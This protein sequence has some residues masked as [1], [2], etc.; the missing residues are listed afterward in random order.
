[1]DHD[2]NEKVD[3]IEG[4]R[5]DDERNYIQENEGTAI[6]EGHKEK[7]NDDERNF[8]QENEDAAIQDGPGKLLQ[9]PEQGG[10][11]SD[12][13]TLISEEA[14]R[15][16][17]DFSDG[18]PES[19]SGDE[20]SISG[21]TSSNL[22][23]RYQDDDESSQ[24]N[25]KSGVDSVLSEESSSYCSQMEVMSPDNH[26][27][28]AR[29]IVATTKHGRR[30]KVSTTRSGTGLRWITST[31]TKKK[32][33]SQD[34]SLASAI[35][36]LSPLR[37]SQSR[38]S[39]L[40]LNMPD[41]LPT[42]E[43]H[44]PPLPPPGKLRIVRCQHCELPLQVPDD[45]PPNPESLQ[46]L[47]CRSCMN[48]STFS[49]PQAEGPNVG[50][51]VSFPSS[52]SLHSQSSL[53]S[54]LGS[55][56]LSATD[57]DEMAERAPSPGA[58]AL[59]IN[60]FSAAQQAA[61]TTSETTSVTS[62]ASSPSSNVSSMKF[63][64]WSDHEPS[65]HEEISKIASN[66]DLH[67]TAL[68]PYP[69]SSNMPP[70]DSSHRSHFPALRPY[71]RFYNMPPNSSQ[72]SHFSERVLGGVSSS[73]QPTFGSDIGGI[74]YPSL[75]SSEKLWSEIPPTSDSDS[76]SFLPSLLP[77]GSTQPDESSSRSP[78]ITSTRKRVYDDE[79][80]E[81][82]P[83]VLGL[84]KTLNLNFKKT[85]RTGG[86]QYRRYRRKVIVNGVRIPDHL[87]KK[88]EQKAGPIHPGTY[89]WASLYPTFTLFET[90][91]SNCHWGFN[92]ILLVID[93]WKS[94]RYGEAQ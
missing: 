11:S 83:D 24:D 59:F 16:E 81:Q 64:S 66:H 75:P 15:S 5:T 57:Q 80:N 79:P 20:A 14:E 6:R 49:I 8:I 13:A 62:S 48:V 41:Q 44:Y 43:G 4:K 84:R 90:L 63:S 19:D 86:N 69:G 35:P 92:A 82:L 34:P 40:F 23:V 60:S 54:S 37:L 31:S 67:D 18:E 65:Q 39:Y 2:V 87:V 46:K 88:A 94:A 93:S 55:E 74:G 12:A 1:M 7:R 56:E 73:I 26:L 58:E 27:D 28:A 76:D 50:H 30:E 85:N 42:E 47:R 77:T 72:V 22:G 68:G 70:F 25:V 78:Q 9:F 17:L 3:F 71:P 61:L 89:W 51:I 29:M 10:A 21:T 52:D 33:W 45:L 32:Q 91:T 38:L 36:E 53:A